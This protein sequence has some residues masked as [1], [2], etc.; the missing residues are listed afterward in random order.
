MSMEYD[1]VLGLGP[2]SSAQGILSILLAN[3]SEKVVSIYVKN[4]AKKRGQDDG[5]ISIGRL[6]TR[7]CEGEW[8]YTRMVS[9]KNWKVVAKRFDLNLYWVVQKST[10]FFPTFYSLPMMFGS[11][12]KRRIEVRCVDG[13]FGGCSAGIHKLGKKIGCRKI[14]HL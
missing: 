1:G 4:A 10:S 2:T 9:E 7:H 8:K 14:W 12:L 11:K 13:V 6:D 5:R 3:E